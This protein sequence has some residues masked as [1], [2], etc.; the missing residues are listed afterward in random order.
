MEKRDYLTKEERTVLNAFLQDTDSGRFTSQD[1]ADQLT[2]T[3]SL[4]PY[5]ITRYMLEKGWSLRRVD[6]R[7]VW[8]KR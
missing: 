4:S 6:D 5:D 7:L 8:V 2:D 1:I 3:I